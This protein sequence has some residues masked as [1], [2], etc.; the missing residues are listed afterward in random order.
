MSNLIH[1]PE[2]GSAALTP[3]QFSADDIATIKATVAKDATDSE[4]KL[5][6][7]QCLR[8]GL[9]PLTRQIYFIKSRD[10]M[11]VTISIDGFRI[12]AERSGRYEGQL[13]PQWCGPDG[14]WRDVWLETGQ[15]AAARV[16]IFRSG[17]REVLWGVATWK[18]FNKGIGQW[19]SMGAH[20]LAKVAEALAL[21]KA[22]P[23]D[24][25]GLYTSD[26]MEGLQ[27][28]EAKAEPAK[29]RKSAAPV[30]T[31]PPTTQA[32]AAVQLHEPLTGTVVTPASRNRS[33]AWKEMV[34]APGFVPSVE[35]IPACVEFA[36]SIL[37]RPIADVKA[38]TIEDIDAVT[39]ELN[40]RASGDA[41][42][43]RRRFYAIAGPAANDQADR[44]RIGVAIGRTVTSRRDVTAEEWTKAANAAD[45][46]FSDFNELAP[47]EVA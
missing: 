17:F 39:A 28:T 6:L 4:L 26:E 11:Q 29:Q 37:C 47:Q 19:P 18:E 38:L 41:D 22:F 31:N 2:H 8:T 36:S 35:D 3:V 30:A 34:Q 44:V 23:N 13:G 33:V 12:V 27:T 9:D 32:E 14:N 24:L 7:A 40:R 5:F 46:P 16:G 45:D 21:R 10:K 15:P 20:M 25:S 42:S 43:E 1:M